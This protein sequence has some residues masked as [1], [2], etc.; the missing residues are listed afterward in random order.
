MYSLYHINP[1]VQTSPLMYPPVSP[2][3][4]I[5]SALQPKPL[6]KDRFATFGY[7]PS[8]NIYLF[9][10]HKG[11]V[12]RKYY[13]TKLRLHQYQ[14]KNFVQIILENSLLFP[15]RWL[16]GRGHRE[17]RR[18]KTSIWRRYFSSSVYCC[19]IIANRWPDEILYL[20]RSAGKFRR[21]Q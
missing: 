9:I 18:L 7:S 19:H 11:T 12:I 20:P 10:H 3:L 4:A 13:T 1:H 21:C 8:H 14:R 6:F 2:T 16:N 17:N 5:S 15:D